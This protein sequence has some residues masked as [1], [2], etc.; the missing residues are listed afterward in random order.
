MKQATIVILILGLLGAFTASSVLSQEEARRY[1]ALV[2]E[3][4][5]PEAC[6]ATSR[7]ADQFDVDV[8]DGVNPPVSVED[9]HTKW[10][11]IKFAF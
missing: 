5:T 9:N 8:S 11:G 4:T 3:S 2:R 6:V 1:A 7:A 10:F